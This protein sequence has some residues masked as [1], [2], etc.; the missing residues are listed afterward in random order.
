VPNAFRL[1]L[2]GETDRSRLEQGLQIVS[3]LLL[4]T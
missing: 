1:A 4:G 3:Q 2:G